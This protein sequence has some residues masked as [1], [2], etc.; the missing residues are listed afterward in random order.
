[1]LEEGVILEGIVKNITDYGAFVDLG[2]ID[3]LLHVTDMSWG[4]VGAS[5]RGR[6]RRRPGA[7]R[8]PQVRSRARARV[9]RHEADHARP[10]DDGADRYPDRHAR[11]RQGR[12]PHR[13][14]RLRRARAGHRGP[15]PRL[16]DVV[17]QARDAI[18]RRCSSRGTG[19]RRRRCSTSTR[20]NRRISLG[21]KQAE[22]NP[23]EMVR[24]QPSRSA[25]T[26]RAR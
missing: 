1:M 3:G 22:P 15:D 8:R 10:V 23:W 6:Q 5:V 19:G 12:E 2:G 13:L 16:R 17:D 26:S 11:A 20:S 9:A 18:R 14:R 7:R 25:A 24:D 4:R 21:L